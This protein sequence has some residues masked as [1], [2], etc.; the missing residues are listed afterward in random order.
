MASG[1]NYSEIY[2]Q[3]EKAYLNGNYQRAASIIDQMMEE[4][5]EDPS[6][7]LLR[8]HIYCYGLQD[9]EI[10]KQR[11][12]SYKEFTEFFEEKEIKKQ[13]SKARSKKKDS[14]DDPKLGFW[15]GRGLNMAA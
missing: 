4:F 10:A 9:Y 1:I 14:G 6:V 12:K 5:P 15:S 13:K 8:G 7:L 11:V 2:E 3:A